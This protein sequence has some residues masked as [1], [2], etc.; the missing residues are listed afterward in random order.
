MKIAIL[1]DNHLDANLENYP[2]PDLNVDELAQFLDDVRPT[3]LTVFALGHDGLAQYPS[4]IAKVAPGL[5][6]DLPELWRKLAR[7]RGID[8]ALYASTLRNDILVRERPDWERQRMDGVLSGR[9]DHASPYVDEW[10]KPFLTELLDRYDP[11]GFFFDGDYW[12][13]GEGKNEHRRLAGQRLMGWAGPVDAE[14]VADQRKLTVETYG[15]YIENL[16]SF[17]HQRPR[18]L[19]CSVNLAFTFRHPIPPPKGLSL[20]TSDLPP[21]FGPLDAWIET[22]VVLDPGQEREVVMPLFVEPEGG[23]R[24]YP[25][26]PD[27]LVHEVSPLLAADESVHVYFPM[28]LE[29]RI[30]TSYTASLNEMRA[31]IERLQLAATM[32]APVFEPDVL[33]LADSE[34]L[35]QSQDFARLRGAMLG[36]SVAGLN[37]GAAATARC[38]ARLERVRTLI[39]PDGKA[40]SSAGQRVIE[41]ALDLGVSVI[42]HDDPDFAARMIRANWDVDQ[43]LVDRLLGAYGKSGIVTPWSGMKIERHWSVFVRGL[44]APDGAWR[45]FFWNS[46]EKGEQLGRHVLNKG[47]GYA[48]RVRV[49]LPESLRTHRVWGYADQSLATPQTIEFELTGPFAVIEGGRA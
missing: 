45:L 49:Q 31:E 13:V 34:A 35:Q 40:L 9:I 12:A 16:A 29:G 30:D 5:R 19:K 2:L 48:G 1:V 22:A 32:T 42:G 46:V 41:K 4:S 37:V 24:K 28:T 47:S 26:A 21:F 14:S 25:K 20:I 43:D 36:A 6:Y 7:E 44:L 18:E 10:L 39:V 23:G 33:C 27:Q 11:D 38:A 17:L 3:R 8:Y 15:E